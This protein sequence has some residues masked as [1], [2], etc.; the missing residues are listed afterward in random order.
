METTEHTPRAPTPVPPAARPG[1]VRSAYAVARP[2]D[3]EYLVRE[4]DRRRFRET[5]MLVLVVS[6]VVLVLTLFTWV[7]LEVLDTSYRI[8][9]LEEDLH[10]LERRRSRLQL[11]AAFLSS[12]RVLDETARELGLEAPT[13]DQIL[14]YE[15]PRP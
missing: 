7:Q 9:E 10:E 8:E 2:V 13:I 3:N 12:P 15:G 11:D 4:R 5:L 1:R 14:Y 6:P